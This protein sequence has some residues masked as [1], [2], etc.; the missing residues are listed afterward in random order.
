MGSFQERKKERKKLGKKE[1]AMHEGWI[2]I[3]AYE[4]VNYISGR[5]KKISK[6]EPL[7]K[8]KITHRVN[9]LLC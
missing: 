2:L 8:S 4:N 3:Q 9:I 7:S 1:K 5:R 6:K